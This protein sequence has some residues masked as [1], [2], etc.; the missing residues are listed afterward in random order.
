MTT[1]QLP[2]ALEAPAPQHTAPGRGAPPAPPEPV[3]GPAFYVGGWKIWRVTGWP[4]GGKQMHGWQAAKPAD[5]DR[6]RGVFG[7]YCPRV[8]RA[9]LSAVSPRLRPDDLP[10]D[11]YAR[12]FERDVRPGF[13][14]W[15][16]WP[17]GSYSACLP[18]LELNIAACRLMRTSEEF[19]AQYRAE[20]AA[21]VRAKKDKRRARRA[22]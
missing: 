7:G 5:T 17:A 14:H 15:I 9:Y 4:F 8:L 16:H 13:T 3:E 22:A 10:A 20:Q 21:A 19:L 6:S 1:E 12:G 11:L 2:L 18:T